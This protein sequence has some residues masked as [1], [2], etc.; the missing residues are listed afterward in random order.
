[1]DSFSFAIG[2]ELDQ[3][4]HFH[5]S[6]IGIVVVVVVGGGAAVAVAV[7]LRSIRNVAVCAIVMVVM[8]EV[9]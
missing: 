2:L 8:I 1:M 6:T 3:W 7:L 5:V 4:T 9:I